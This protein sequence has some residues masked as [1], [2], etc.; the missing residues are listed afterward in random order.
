MMMALSKT[1]I[2]ERLS[3]EVAESDLVQQALEAIRKHLGMEAAYLSEFVDGKAVFRCVDAPGM[4]HVIDVGDAH[5]LE[6]TY[7]THI[8]EGRLPDLIPDTSKNRLA[9]SMAITETLQIG[10]HIAIP[11]KRRN[12][13]P[14]GMVCCLSKSPHDSLNPRDL[15][16]MRMFAE[17]VSRQVNREIEERSEQELKANSVRSILKGGE[18]SIAYQPIVDLK[19]MMTAGFEAL[20][21]FEPLPYR[22]PD[23][24][25]RDAMAAGLGC[26]LELAV[27]GKALEFIDKAPA[28]LFLTLNVSPETVSSG[29]LA[30]LLA[31]TPLE[32]LV[33]EL[34]EHT[35]VDDYSA[36][37]DTLAPLIAGGVRI[38][39]DDAGAGYSSFRHILQL[40]PDIIK[41]DINLTRHVDNDPG[42]R[43]LTTGIMSYAHETG[44]MVIAEGIETV[45]EKRTLKA[46]GVEMG[47]GYL[48]GYPGELPDAESMAA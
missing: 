34:T 31:G 42:R 6:E 9:R 30:D 18:F 48:L 33:L 10:S 28:D 43:A 13:E 32:R 17:L 5:L 12:G 25:F 1:M 4:T 41:L 20:C 14:Y 15:E 38:A 23:A 8:L 24:W 27:L 35:P 3:T 46:L 29:R 21:R 37:R 16:T 11:V 47:Q 40:R 22:P 45:R 36:L 7:C 19:T 26:D 2:G 44:A 39:V